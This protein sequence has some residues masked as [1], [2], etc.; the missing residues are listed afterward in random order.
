[1]REAL[2]NTRQVELE[3]QKYLI[4]TLEMALTLKFAPMISPNREIRKKY[5]DAHDFMAMVE[6]H[7]DIDL[8]KLA[9]LGELVYHGGGAE[10][11]KMVGQARRGETL[12]L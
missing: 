6:R 11:V 12:N 8:D 9:E 4:P 5:Q 10:L 7:P 1:M 2:K 3:G